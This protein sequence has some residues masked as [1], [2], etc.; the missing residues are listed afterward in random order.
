MKLS[1]NLLLIFFSVFTVLSS[2]VSQAAWTTIINPSDKADKALESVTKQTKDVKVE[3]LVRSAEALV[4]PQ[5]FEK[6][7]KESK[8]V[9]GLEITSI[10]HGD[11]FFYMQAGPIKLVFK[12][13]DKDNVA[14]KLNGHSFSYEEAANTDLWQ[15]KIV[16]VIKSYQT[17]HSVF[18]PEEERF[19]KTSAKQD[20][21]SKY[22][23]NLGNGFTSMLV[24]PF[25]F[26]ASEAEAFQINWQSKWTWTAIGAGVI[27]LVAAIY[28]KKHKK[29]HSK[30]KAEISSKLSQAR[31]NLAAAQEGGEQNL[32]SYQKQVTDLETLLAEYNS[33]SN[34]VG[35]FGFLFG[36][37]TFKP[38]MYDSIM[39]RP[40]SNTGTG[41]PG[42][43]TAPPSSSSGTY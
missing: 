6:L 4:S 13:I 9:K 39:S 5:E 30:N 23:L 2:R 33:S 34:N 24:L 12:W 27:A 18:A 36:N 22:I 29:E 21:P 40:A 43:P 31:A 26:E 32:A 10:M 25:L 35:F 42:S 3:D 16:E 17:P 7:I 41:V 20:I 37:R 1:F 14:F 38:A 19:F 11:D 28:Y 8:K 15:K